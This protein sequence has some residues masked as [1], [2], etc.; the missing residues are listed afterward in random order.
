MV[1]TT[2]NKELQVGAT[3]LVLDEEGGMRT[4]MEL[5]MKLNCEVGKLPSDTCT[6]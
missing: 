5:M 6:C 4:R 1:E 3:F 2:T